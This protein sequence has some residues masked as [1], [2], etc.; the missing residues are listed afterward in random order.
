MSEN[1]PTTVLDNDNQSDTGSVEDVEPTGTLG[2]RK[3]RGGK[4]VI[5]KKEAKELIG[6]AGKAGGREATKA[7]EKEPSLKINIE[8]D[9][10]VHV[11]LDAH[12][13][14][15]IKIAFYVHALPA[16]HRHVIIA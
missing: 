8:L 1:D 6:E 13:E 4:G 16:D 14:G 5:P 7:N 12:L 3:G 10:N 15:W 11:E 2:G 9:L